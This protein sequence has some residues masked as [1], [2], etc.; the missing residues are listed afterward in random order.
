M[1]LFSLALAAG[2]SVTAVAAE[3]PILA[4]DRSF[5]NL[6]ASPCADFYAYAN[7]AFDAVPIPGEYSAYGVNQ[8]IDE[9]NFAILKDILE[10]A[11]RDG[12]P[13][14]GVAQRVGD[15]YASGMDEAAIERDGLAPVQPWLDAIDAI[16]TP[17]ELM[18]AI[19]RLQAAGVPVGFGFGVRVDDKNSAAMIGRFSQG[20]LGLPERDYYFRPGENAEGIR[21]AYVAHVGRMLELSGSAAA[22]AQHAAAAIMA[23]ET[24]LA[25]A[26]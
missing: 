13:K 3:K 5:M 15:F 25:K 4:V 20:G 6:T 9:R 26:S 7:G 10:T 22:D 21:T 19:A 1:R 23:L 12:G 11:A 18:D 14:G 16:T 17:H 8:E 24:K 2:L